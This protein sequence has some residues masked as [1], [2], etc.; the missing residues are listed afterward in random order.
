MSDMSEEHM[1]SMCT[2]YESLL[3]QEQENNFNLRL[4]QN[5]SAEEWAGGDKTDVATRT[6]CITGVGIEEICTCILGT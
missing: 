2:I 5:R 6:N 1:E 3:A 4:K